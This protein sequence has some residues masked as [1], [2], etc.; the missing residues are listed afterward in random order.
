MNETNIRRRFENVKDRLPLRVS[1]MPEPDMFPERV[2]H[3][4]NG[5]EIA[6]G[7]FTDEIGEF[8][9]HAGQDIASLLGESL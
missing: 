3:D 5:I 7:M 9:A 1:P 6:R 4:K 8:L 2:I